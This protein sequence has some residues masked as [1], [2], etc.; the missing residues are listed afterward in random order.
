[1]LGRDAPWSQTQ[2]M[3]VHSRIERR[4]IPTYQLPNPSPYPMYF[5][6]RVYQGSSGQIYPLPY[7]EAL[8][9]VATDQDWTVITLENEFV[10]V[11][12]MPELGG[13]ILRGYDK[14]CV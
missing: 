14:C 6:Q 2:L 12:I 1:M 9:D 10:L 7:F 4:S 11:E 3:T 13:R 5:D 8:A